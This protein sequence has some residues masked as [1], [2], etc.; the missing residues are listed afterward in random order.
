VGSTALAAYKDEKGA[1]CIQ[2]EFENNPIGKL[3]Q[4]ALSDEEVGVE[5]LQW[6]TCANRPCSAGE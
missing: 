1:L 4:R 2:N 5:K 3:C 6:G